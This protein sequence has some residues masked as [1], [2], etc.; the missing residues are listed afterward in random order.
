MNQQGS[1]TQRAKLDDVERHSFGVADK[2]K[3]TK[4]RKEGV[5]PARLTNGII[6][7][8]PDIVKYFRANFTVLSQFKQIPLE[9]TQK[10]KSNDIRTIDK[11]TRSI[12]RTTEQLI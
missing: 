12:N 1:G 8:L 3:T 9:A 7:Q 4:G 2:Y 10:T 5:A 6:S 11:T